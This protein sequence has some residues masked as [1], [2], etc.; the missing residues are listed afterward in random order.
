MRSFLQSCEEAKGQLQDQLVLLEPLDP[1]CSPGTL[2][3]QERTQTQALRDIH[4][5]ER[6]IAYLKSVAKM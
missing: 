4:T 6:K 3:A 1:G 2:L 5:L